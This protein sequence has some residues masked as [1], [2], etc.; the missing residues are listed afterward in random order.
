MTSKNAR[1]IAT[2]N[3]PYETEDSDNLDY[4]RFNRE[5]GRM[6]GQLRL[7]VRYRKYATPWF[8]YLM[9]SREEMEEILNGTGWRVSKFIDTGDSHFA[10]VIEKEKARK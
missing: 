1:I 4:H 8:D 9:V 3:N 5:R 10:A 2:T 7:K 6:G